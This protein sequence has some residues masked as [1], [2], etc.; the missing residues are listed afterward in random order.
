MVVTIANVADD[1]RVAAGLG[2]GDLRDFAGS[3]LLRRVIAD[4]RAGAEGRMEGQAIFRAD[5]DGLVCDEEGQLSYG[6]GAALVATRR[7]LWRSPARRWI[8]VSFAD[9]RPFHGFAL[10]ASAEAVHICGPD[11]YE[12]CYDFTR[13]PDWRAVWRVAGPRKD[14]VSVTDYG[15]SR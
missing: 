3:W 13:W 12:V 1:G 15:P 14:Y 11:R 7:Y 2:P 4:A 6:G 9:G 8:A 5:R 10:G